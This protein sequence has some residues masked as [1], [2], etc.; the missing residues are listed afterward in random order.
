MELNSRDRRL[1]CSF[2]EGGRISTQ[3]RTLWMCLSLIVTSGCMLSLT[4]PHWLVD[5]STGNSLGLYNHCVRDAKPRALLLVDRWGSPSGTDSGP[6]PW[7]TCGPYGGRYDLASLPS[8]AWQVACV[9]YGGGCVLMA[10]SAAAVCA[11]LGIQHMMRSSEATERNVIN[12]CVVG[13]CIGCVQA[14]AGRM[15]CCVSRLGIEWINLNE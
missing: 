8:N 4:Q 15:Y 2:F 7:V 5:R 13:R 3:V 12:R 11:L 6:F 10:V 1:P 9:L 14:M